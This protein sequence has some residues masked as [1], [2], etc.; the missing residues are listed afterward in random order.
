MPSLERKWG[1]DW[2]VC[3]RAERLLQAS[4]ADIEHRRGDQVYYQPQEDKI[5][6][7]E[8][9]KFRTPADYYATALHELGHW[10]GHKDRLDRESLHQGSKEGSGS[11]A[12]AKEELRA[13][14]TSMTVN[15][16][17]SLPHNARAP[18]LLCGLLDQDAQKGSRRAGP[19]GE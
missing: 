17:M 12:L 1:Q 15:G 3:E 19:G 11:D 9:E 10:S 2:E 6:L 7:P 18:G 8:P 16:V 13:E 4:G 5:V 14:M